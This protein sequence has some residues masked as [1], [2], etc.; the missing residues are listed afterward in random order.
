MCEKY[1]I[2]LNLIM[3][4]FMNGFNLKKT[5]IDV[6]EQWKQLYF[7]ESRQSSGQRVGKSELRNS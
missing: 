2:S 7:V 4:A 3:P 6:K 1:W 5:I